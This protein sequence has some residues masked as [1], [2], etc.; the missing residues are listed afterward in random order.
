[1]GV[2]EKADVLIIGGGIMGCSLAYRLAK[3]KKSVILV[4]RSHVGAEPKKQI[5]KEVDQKGEREMPFRG[6]KHWW[7]LARA[8]IHNQN[9]TGVI[10][11]E[12]KGFGS[13]LLEMPPS[14]GGS[15]EGRFSGPFDAFGWLESEK[16]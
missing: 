6:R 14:G 5:R 10:A 7:S 3:R 4:E 15:T 9:R 12:S 8:I 13:V 16:V 11:R 2:V 1:M